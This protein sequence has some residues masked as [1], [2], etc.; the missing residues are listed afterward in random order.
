MDNHILKQDVLSGYPSKDYDD[1]T[2]SIIENIEEVIFLDEENGWINNDGDKVEIGTWDRDSRIATLDNKIEQRGKLL[3]IEVNNATIDGTGAVIGDESVAI[4]IVGQHDINLKNFII[5][6]CELAMYI[7]FSREISIEYISFKENEQA[8]SINRSSEIKIKNNLIESS[9]NS[10]VGI[11]ILD[12]GKVIIQDNSIY[13]KMRNTS[14]DSMQ[15]S[16]S[17]V[18]TENSTTIYIINN[19]IE[20]IDGSSQ[21]DSLESYCINGY[22]INSYS[23]NDTLI[24]YNNLY[25]KNNNLNLSNCNSVEVNL[26]SIYLD[27]NN[28]RI[29]VE[30][31]NVLV[32]GNNIDVSYNEGEIGFY[33]ILC[34][35]ENNGN[36][37]KNNYISINSNIYNLNS[38][39]KNDKYIYFTGILLDSYNNYNEIN[40]NQ[41]ELQENIASFKSDLDNVINLVCGVYFNLDNTTNNIINN[42]FIIKENNIDKSDSITTNFSLVHLYY[43]NICNTIKGNNLNGS[44]GNGIVL[45]SKNDVTEI[46][47]NNIMEN[48]TNGILLSKLKNIEMTNTVTIMDNSI[49]NNGEYGLYITR[50]NY[51]NIIRENNFISKINK[52]I[53]DDNSSEFMN[54]Y[55]KNYYNDQNG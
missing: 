40:G 37:I 44:Q 55:E 54:Y 7:E 18:A 19:E 23:T 22:C 45:V 52:N 8:V 2:T 14:N 46:L 15:N 11:F 41:I 53:Y 30:E 28:T 39:T 21:I 20:V 33:G 9:K 32:G 17:G 29:D 5:E 36:S 31:N 50:G 12:S 35:N 1:K 51:L 38:T 49:I 27:S 43:N 13:I 24:K 34:S 4:N 16:Y 10:C 26:S 25:I 3:V 42:D 6:N 48:S 47:E